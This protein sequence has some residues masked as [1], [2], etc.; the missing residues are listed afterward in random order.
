MYCTVV[1][2]DNADHAAVV[3]TVGDDIL[4]GEEDERRREG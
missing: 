3:A 1:G 2:I 4:G